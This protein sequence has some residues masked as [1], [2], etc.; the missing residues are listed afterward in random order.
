MPYLKEESGG[1]FQKEEGSGILLL[2]E[3]STYLQPEFPS[4]I[5]SRPGL[6]AA[7]L[8]GAFFAVF[9]LAAPVPSL[10][11]SPEYPD[12][13]DG[14]AGLHA[15]R[16][17]SQAWAPQT[18]APPSSSWAPEYADRIDRRAVLASQQQAI[19]YQPALGQ[20][21]VTPLAWAA[22]YPDRITPPQARLQGS[23][24]AAAALRAD[25]VST[26]T[27]SWIPI[28][29]DRI[30]RAALLPHQQLSVA[31]VPALGQFS[32][33]ALSW[34]AQYPAQNQRRPLPIQGLRSEPLIIIAAPA[35]PLSWA[36]T[37]PDR[38]DGRRFPA[39]EQVSHAYVPAVGQFP[40]PFLS[41]KGDFPAQF[42]RPLPRQQFNEL[43]DFSTQITP[44]ALIGD[45]IVATAVP[46]VRARTAPMLEVHR[47]TAGMEQ[48]ASAREPRRTVTS[49]WPRR[50]TEKP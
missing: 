38:I 32:V 17:Q 16:Q 35:P 40:V 46:T 11:W 9:Q 25:V 3:D 10:A 36:A 22:E 48:A 50:T 21:P 20:F 13:I 27:L 43:A 31:Y 29:P 7:I 18:I 2:E 34:A 26:P 6:S 44:P 8:A 47:T 23:Q 45:V 14:K 37:Y 19:A 24:D 1:Y 28:Y 4:R 12:R 33:P 5:P 15:S 39:S 41:W 30:L 49:L 42:L